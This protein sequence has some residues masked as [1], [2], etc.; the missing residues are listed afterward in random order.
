MNSRDLG[1]LA[2]MATVGF[3]AVTLLPEGSHAG[4][5]WPTGLAAGV[6]LLNARSR[7]A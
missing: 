1:L 2:L 5:M 7:W 4:E 3:V 6:L